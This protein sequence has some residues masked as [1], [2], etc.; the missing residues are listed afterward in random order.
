MT[1]R[2][3]ILTSGGDCQALNATMRG[4]AKTLYN[5]VDDLEIIGFKRGYQGLMHEDYVKMKPKDFDDIID[6]GGTILG[7]SRSPFKYMQVIEDGFDKVKAMIKTYKKLKLDAL[8]VLGGNGSVKTA[9]LL[10]QKGLN[11][12]ALPKTI[13]NDTWGTDYTF[14]FQSA[15]DVATRYLDDILTTAKSHSRIFV[16]EVMGH[17]V[18]HITLRA[19]LAAGC[20]IILLPEIP[21]D[22]KNIIKRIKKREKHGKKYTI[23][24]C[25][26]GAITKEDAKLSKK[27]YKAKVAARNGQSVVVEVAKEI[28]EAFPEKEVRTAVIGHAQRGGSPDA[29]DRTISTL[30]GIEGAR[31]IMQRS[32]GRFVVLK[33]SDITSIPLADTAGK[34]DYVDPKSKTVTNAKLMGVTF[35]DE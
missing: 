15:I 29:Y 30:F 16:V 4:L 35:G 8:A 34:L 5:N 33:G 27:K 23:I 26:E 3:G 31:L 20:D 2:V 17:K 9:N 14:G 7:T 28:Q 12:I 22:M 6:L 11:V 32:F 25:A 18:G 13:D 19:G 1:L 21:Y 10:S 24:A